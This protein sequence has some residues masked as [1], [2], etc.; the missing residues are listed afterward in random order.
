MGPGTGREQEVDDYVEKM[1]D[2]NSAEHTGIFQC[3]ALCCK[4]KSNKGINRHKVKCVDNLEVDLHRV[5]C[6]DDLDMDQMQICALPEDGLGSLCGNKSTRRAVVR[7]GTRHTLMRYVASVHDIS[8][9]V[10][11]DCGASDDFLSLHIAK[12]AHLKLT[13]LEEPTSA[14]L[15]NGS[16]M[17]IRYMAKGVPVQI[18]DYMCLVDFKVLTMSSL[19]MVLGKPWFND[20]D[21][22]M[23]WK[24]NTMHIRTPEGD[25]TIAPNG[26]TASVNFQECNLMTMQG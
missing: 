11:A 5:K 2:F 6:V 16:S 7:R 18:G 9:E 13:E 15:A 23:S 1:M 17:Q 19:S 22:H 25:F 4:D 10:L 8:V 26:S 14:T 3:E 21:P 20:A 24:T 12:R